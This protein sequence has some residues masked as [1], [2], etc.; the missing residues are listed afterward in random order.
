M[1]TLLGSFGSGGEN[2]FGLDAGLLGEGVF[3]RVDADL[4]NTGGDLTVEPR[5]TPETVRLRIT[6]GESET[7]DFVDSAETGDFEASSC[8]GDSEF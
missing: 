6:V 2:T 7:L 1:A 4:R 3:S 5:T 8:E